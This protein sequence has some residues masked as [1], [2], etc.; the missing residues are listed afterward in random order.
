M[1]ELRAHIDVDAMVEA[2][3]ALLNAPSP[4][5][6]HREVMPVARRLF[7]ELAIPDLVISETRKGALLLTWR[8]RDHS[9]PIGLTAHLDTLG[10]MV[11]EILSDGTLR[12]TSL[13]SISWPGIE[14]ENCTIRTHEDRRYRGTVMLANPS[15]HTNSEVKTARRDELSMVLRIDA[16]SSSRAETEA[17][18]IGVGDFVFVDPRVEL[19][20]TGFIRARFLDDK[21]SVATIYGA[22]LALKRAGL[23]P[24]QDLAILLSNYEEVGH[25]GAAGWPADLAELVVVDMAALGTGQTGDEFNVSLCVK[26]RGGPYHFD[27]NEKLRRIARTHEIP[28]RVD[29]YVN[30]SSDGTAY[31][32]AGGEAKVALIGPGVASSHGYERTHRDALHH[33]AHLIARYLL[34]EVPA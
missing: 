18:G 30:Y 15:T 13:G 25:G 7:E 33:S 34:D 11:K 1:P 17:L 16:R 27:L 24:A 32:H 8:G 22:L 23:R 3:V 31:W 19:V 28:L 21:A 10:L 20:D 5:G 9:A 29:I 14:F 2:L 6:Y 12:L 26:D 4:T